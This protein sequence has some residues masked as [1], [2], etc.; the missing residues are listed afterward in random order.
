VTITQVE[1]GVRVAGNGLTLAADIYGDIGGSPVVLAHGGGQ[2]RHAWGAT[3]LRL[4]ERGRYAV[5]VDLRGHGESEWA[6]NG[7]YE[8]EHTAGDLRAVVAQVGRPA[9][10]VGASLGGISALVAIAEAPD[11]A[12]VG[13]A[14]VLVDV[15][16]RVEPA[17][18]ERIK[19]FMT[20]H[21]DGFGS[22]E[23]VADAIAA[24]NP[25]RPRPARLDG[26]RKNLRQR[27]DGRWIWHWDP[28]ILADRQDEPRVVRN[29]RRLAAA[30]RGLT[31][32]VLIVRGGDSDLLSEDGVRHLRELVSH[33]EVAR[34]PGA[35][36]MVA[37][38]RNDAFN[39]AIV[40]FLDRAV[41]TG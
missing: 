29:E 39:E 13:S 14:L 5:N 15:A 6:P 16:P 41:P 4:A 17:G 2:T 35:G 36:H 40:D 28:E 33:A 32:P 11:P 24:Y 25:H 31:I 3:A 1:H 12:A 20:G 37:G 26:L 18:V 23:E 9:A 19:A 30:A 10:L 22:L 7:E 34:V 8:L 21:P 27:P 38:D